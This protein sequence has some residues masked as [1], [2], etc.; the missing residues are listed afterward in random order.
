MLKQ[1]RLKKKIE[2]IRAQ[3]TA[4]DTRL[5]EIQAREAELETAIS[6]AANDDDLSLVD[7]E[8]ATVT[9]E[10]DELTEKK[11]ALAAEIEQL[12][13]ELEELNTAPV[14]EIEPDT[15]MNKTT[16]VIRMNQFKFF[17]TMNRDAVK[18]TVERA[19]VKE[20]ISRARNLV[21]EKRTVTGAEL[22][23][24]TILL[25]M[26]RDSL[27]TYSKLVS[28]VTYKPLKG[29]A[30][31]N[32]TGAIPE[33]VW[34]EMVGKLNELSLSFNQIEVDGYKVGG[35]IAIPNSTLADSDENLADEI[36]Y[37]LGQAIGLALDK[38]ILY[39]TGTKMPVGIVKRLA[40]TVEPAYYGD[41][42]RA[43]TDLHTTNLLLIDASAATDIAF[44]KDLLT[45]IGVIKSE[46]SNGEKFW[47][48]NSKT[49]TAL[50]VKM[51]GINAAGAIVS[52][53]TNTMPLIGGEVVEL[54]FIP[55]N[56]IIG[57]YGSLYILVE[58]EGT[59]FGASEHVQFIEDNT[60]FKGIAR[61]D[62]RPVFGEAFVALNISQEALEVAPVAT[63]VT[64]ALDS[65]NA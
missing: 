59:T 44:Y 54:D 2:L 7:E 42:E 52:G 9:A 6:E 13:R 49:F 22:L 63:A 16:E 29:K 25:D 58:R 55:E 1:L 18:A 26:L 35:F 30:R 48:M 39:G 45:K 15:R 8:I 46:Y 62:G 32:I 31:Q 21:G 5:A 64:F 14:S 51:L 61:Y 40:E 4:H 65:A 56:V 24:P 12:E 53:Q 34:T 17:R 47:A 50:Q 38:A 11:S 3:I 28:K 37:A 43:W 33:G 36:M 23:V 19:E 27:T 60:V 41:N 10:K 20:F 57:G